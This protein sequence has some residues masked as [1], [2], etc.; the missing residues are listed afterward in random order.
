MSHHQGE[1]HGTSARLGCFARLVIFGVAVTI[2]RR[3]TGKVR[4]LKAWCFGLQRSG[5]GIFKFWL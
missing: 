3:F 4:W 2:Q 5:S 1:G